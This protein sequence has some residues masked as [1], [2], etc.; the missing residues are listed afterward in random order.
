[1]L[2]RVAFEYGQTV[3]ALAT[4]SSACSCVTVGEFGVERSVDVETV[5]VFVQTDG[6]GHLMSAIFS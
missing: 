4:S 5:V 2:P 3:C 6:G 1:M